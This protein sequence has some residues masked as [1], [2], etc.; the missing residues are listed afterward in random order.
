MKY[1][2]EL[3]FNFDL[4]AQPVRLTF[5]GR[6]KFP[7]EIGGFLT[8]SIC[9]LI[10]GLLIVQG[11]DLINHL[12]PKVN[13]INLHLLDQPFI[14]ISDRVLMFNFQ[15]LT[16]Q[17]QPNYDPSYFTFSL[18]KFEVDRTKNNE[19]PFNYLNIQLENCSLY[20]DSFN[21][22]A[23]FSTEFELNSFSQSYCLGNHSERIG[24]KFSSD[25]FS[26]L[27]FFFT[28]ICCCISESSRKLT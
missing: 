9:C 14:D 20:F 24:G 28:L 11:N 27:K 6:K 12:K 18:Q 3:L 16:N 25:Y 19:S 13:A 17:F 2:R 23:N 22:K 5:N 4:F 26:N 8:I 7:T 1:L 10:V 15:I 21:R